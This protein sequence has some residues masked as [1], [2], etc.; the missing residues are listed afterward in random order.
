MVLFLP[1]TKGVSPPSTVEKGERFNREEGGLNI[2]E[3]LAFNKFT[4]LY[5]QTSNFVS[6]VIF[7]G[8]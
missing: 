8:H 7:R 6:I 4:G 5:F 2:V 3:N 1:E